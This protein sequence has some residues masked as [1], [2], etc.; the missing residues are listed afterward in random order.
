MFS[1][2]TPSAIG[3][4][5]MNTPPIFPFFP[6]LAEKRACDTVAIQWASICIDIPMLCEYCSLQPSAA[7]NLLLSSL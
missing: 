2:S 3:T 4:L 6:K 7:T 1:M 5:R